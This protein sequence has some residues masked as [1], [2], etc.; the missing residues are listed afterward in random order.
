M[1]TIRTIIAIIAAVSLSSCAGLTFTL[2]TPYGD[3]SSTDGGAVSIVARPIIPA[4]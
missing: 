2:S 3:A 1:T 4:K